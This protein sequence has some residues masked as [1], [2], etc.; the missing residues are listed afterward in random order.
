MP[1]EGEIVVDPMKL[2]DLMR[3]MEIERM[4]FPDPWPFSAFLSDLENEN[5]ITLVAKIDGKVVGFTICHVVAEEMH[6][7]NIAVDPDFR[8]K[9]VGHK[10]I[11][12]L[13]YSGEQHGCRIMYLDVRKS[14]SGAIS[15]YNKYGFEV[16]YERKGYYRKPPEDALVMVLDLSERSKRGV[17]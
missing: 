8:R 15:F 3:V 13:F 2:D 11:E 10:L 1:E 9:K 12:Y 5:T 16:L 14:N 7:M 4:C 6:L 17:V